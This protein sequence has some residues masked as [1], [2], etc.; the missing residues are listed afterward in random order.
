M[1]G[2][3]ILESMDN[4]IIIDEKNKKVLKKCKE[5]PISK[6]KFI[7]EKETL[8]ELK[9]VGVVPKLLS[10]VD[11]SIEVEYLYDY[12]NVTPEKIFETLK[13][14]YNFYGIETLILNK[15]VI[16]KRISNVEK[17]IGSGIRNPVINASIDFLKNYV[18]S[19]KNFIVHETKINGN[20]ALRHL[21]RDTDGNLKIIDWGDSRKGFIEEDIG[22]FR[23][24]ELMFFE[25]EG[26]EPLHIKK[27]LDG[28]EALLY[29]DDLIDKKSLKLFSSL[30]HIERIPFTNFYECNNP[31]KEYLLKELSALNVI[32]EL[33]LRDIMS[34]PYKINPKRILLVTWG[35]QGSVG[36]VATYINCIKEYLGEFGFVFHEI[37]SYEN[38]KKRG[39]IDYFIKL[40]NGQ[41]KRVEKEDIIRHIKKLNVNLVD[42]HSFPSGLDFNGESLVEIIRK[43]VQKPIIYTAHVCVWDVIK[44]RSY[45]E[46]DLRC[47]NEAS[48]FVSNQYLL[49][50]YLETFRNVLKSKKIKIINQ[51]SGLYTREIDKKKVEEIVNKYKNCWRILYHGRITE[52][53]GILELLAAIEDLSKKFSADDVGLEL[54]M[55]GKIRSGANSIEEI[56]GK[57]LPKNVE[58]FGIVSENRLA[59]IIEASHILVQPT[60]YDSFNISLLEASLYDKPMITF[61][62]FA[63]KYYFIDKYKVAYPVEWS[64]S[65]KERV[66]NLSRAIEDVI[67]N[68]NRFKKIVE[69]GKLEIISNHSVGRF[70]YDYIN[71]YRRL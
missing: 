48:I 3:I 54:F 67:F 50:R 45:I 62:I 55:T 18:I 46:S 44:S 8:K 65:F 21:K 57:K 61:N 59:E 42:I 34:Y 29:Y 7:R 12:Y 43:N 17:M 53:K 35:P 58:Y 69:K 22:Y 30:K 70:I 11:S 68:Y 31:K 40:E 64:D 13:K 33:S 47:I 49:E 19:N 2:V 6:E 32:E 24:E 1:G 39:E 14:I 37:A 10:I 20:L 63:P 15:D 5:F 9:D 26:N 41:W 38:P 23:A 60:H 27:L 71:L 52:D 36:G 66:N 16:L 51:S 28:L 4:R 56:Y 25:K